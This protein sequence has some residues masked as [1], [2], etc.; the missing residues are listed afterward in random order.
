MESERADPDSEGLKVWGGREDGLNRRDGFGRVP[1]CERL[2]NRTLRGR[3]L[4]DGWLRL[5]KPMRVRVEQAS[6]VA[7]C[8]V[9]GLGRGGD[10][11]E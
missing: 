3:Q 11:D 2:R 7:C 10:L 1:L 4:A 8:A 9:R 6:I 5:V